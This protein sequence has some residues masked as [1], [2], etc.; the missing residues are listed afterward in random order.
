LN[1]DVGQ[2]MD[3]K[4][5]NVAKVNSTPLFFDKNKIKI[6]ISKSTYPKYCV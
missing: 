2:A 1:G 4:K 3:K 6:K 5:I